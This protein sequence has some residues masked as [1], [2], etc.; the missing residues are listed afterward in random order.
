MLTSIYTCIYG[1]IYHAYPDVATAEVEA[2]APAVFARIRR[3]VALF[4]ETEAFTM[5]GIGGG[6]N[7]VL[8]PPPVVGQA[9]SHDQ[10][11]SKLITHFAKMFAKH[12]VVWPRRS[13][14]RVYMI[15][16]GDV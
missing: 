10:R 2:D 6:D 4:A 16:G 5:S 12:E 1:C 3:D 7:T 9:V 11:K 13:S 15:A 14:A 8:T